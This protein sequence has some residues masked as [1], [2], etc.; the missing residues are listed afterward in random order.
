MAAR[1]EGRYQMIPSG[2]KK[3]QQIG[4]KEKEWSQAKILSLTYPGN[5][6]FSHST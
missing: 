2:E 5:I 1:M 4:N 3:T 6:Y